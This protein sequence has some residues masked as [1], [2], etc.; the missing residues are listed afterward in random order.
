M[1]QSMATFRRKDYKDSTAVDKARVV[2]QLIEEVYNDIPG[3]DGFYTYLQEI[4]YT[5][6]SAQLRR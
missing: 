5:L 3:A 4:E 1:R 6:Q 2:V